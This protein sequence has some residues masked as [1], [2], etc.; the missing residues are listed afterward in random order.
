MTPS[1]KKFRADLKDEISPLLTS[2]QK[3]DDFFQYEPASYGARS[4]IVFLRPS[5]SSTQ[6]HTRTDDD[7][8]FY[9]ELHVLALYG[10]MVGKV[11]NEEAATDLLDDIEQQVRDAVKIKRRV[12]GKW[13]DLSID[14]RTAITNEPVGGDLY[15]HESITLK[16]RMY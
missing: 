6:G 15:L 13:Q 5:G 7:T 12:E 9:V 14:G 1:R 8:T 2:L 4:P 10:D 16:G 3:Q 11:Y